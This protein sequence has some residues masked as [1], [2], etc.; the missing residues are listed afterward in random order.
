MRI[1][2]IHDTAAQYFMP[3]FMAKTDAAAQRM[4]LQ[5]MGDS[6]GHR[7]D[8]NLYHIGQF[9]DETGEIEPVV[10]H[11]ILR[12]AMIPPEADPRHNPD[13]MNL[14]LEEQSK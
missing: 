14:S 8:Y 6:F 1:Y 5:G 9:N 11:I 7:S 13:Q 12:G 4:F 2:T 10:P 3:L